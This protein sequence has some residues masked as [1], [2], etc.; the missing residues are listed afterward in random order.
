MG[1]D[2]YVNNELQSKV[3]IQMYYKENATDFEFFQKGLDLVA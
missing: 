3:Q 2:R 1:E